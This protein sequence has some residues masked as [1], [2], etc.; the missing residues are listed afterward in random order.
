MKDTRILMMQFC[1]SYA[2]IN[3]RILARRLNVSHMWVTRRN[4]GVTPISIY[5]L[6][7]IAAACGMEYKMNPEQ[8]DCPHC[9]I[10][11]KKESK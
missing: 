9:R 3:Q 11:I 8:L 4:T 2:E 6:M 7:N 5:D 10:V 1:M